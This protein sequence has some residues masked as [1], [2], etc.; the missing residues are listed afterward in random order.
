M[1]KKIKTVAAQIKKHEVLGNEAIQ[2][3]SEL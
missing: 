1:S 3:F 2:D